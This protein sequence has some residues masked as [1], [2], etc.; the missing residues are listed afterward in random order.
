ME[1][2]KQNLS[3][4]KRSLLNETHKE[5]CVSIQL[6]LVETILA[7][8]E[9]TFK[10]EVPYSSENYLKH[11]YTFLTRSRKCKYKLLADLEELKCELNRR[12]TNVKRCLTLINKLLQN[13]LYQNSVNGVINSWTNTTTFKTKTK[14]LHVK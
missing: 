14:T 2:I 12:N 1:S 5:N 11:H 4:I 9:T 3:F 10:Y 8:K 6:I 7:V 13:N